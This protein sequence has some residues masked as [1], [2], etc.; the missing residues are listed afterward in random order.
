[1]PTAPVIRIR[2]FSIMGGNDIRHPEREKRL[3]SH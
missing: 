2:S 1:M 3:W